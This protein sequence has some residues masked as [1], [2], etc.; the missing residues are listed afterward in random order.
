LGARFLIG[1]AY[2]EYM[3]QGFRVFDAHS[4][5]GEWGRWEMKENEVQPFD[6]E[7]LDIED[8]RD[9]MEGYGVE[10]QIVMPHYHPDLSKTFELN[11]LAA[12]MSSEENIYGAVFVEP[13][14]PEETQEALEIAGSNKGIVALKTSAGAWNSSYDP[15]SWSE[16]E[17]MVMEKVLKFSARNDVPVQ[18]HTGHTDSAPEK[19]FK[20][21]DKYPEAVY[22]LVHS[23]GIAGGHFAAL[24]RILDRLET[25]EV[26][27]DTSW[28]RGFAPRWFYRE[29]SRRD[30]LDRMMFATD[31]PWGDF[32]SEFHKILGLK[33]ET[34]ISEEELQMILHDNAEKLYL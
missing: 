31:E 11:T 15:E 19:L 25:H 27:C 29:L 1:E 32:P 8:L 6:R 28:S 23:G 12:E 18:F 22:H 34:D 24:P 26:Y 7:F 14:H 2:S 3:K 5:I 30:A 21:I 10:R 33:K 17:R 16:D 20:I 9:Y 4:H 13:S